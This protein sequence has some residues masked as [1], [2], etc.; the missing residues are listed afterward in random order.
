MPDPSVTY[1]ERFWLVVGVPLWLT[2]AAMLALTLLL[3]GPLLVGLDMLVQRFTHRHSEPPRSTILLRWTPSIVTPAQLLGILFTALLLL[4]I[5]MS[6]IGATFIGFL[7]A[8]PMLVVLSW[9][10]LWLAEVRYRM[11]LDRSLPA[12]VSRLAALLHNGSSFPKALEQVVIDLP[13]GPLRDEWQ[14]LVAALAVPGSVP[15]QVVAALADQTPSARQS[16]LLGHLEVALLQPHT[17]LTERMQAAA[18]ALFAAE[19][20]R[21][22]A[23][24]E[25]AQIRYSGVAIGLAG[26]AMSG[27]LALTQASR[28]A[29]AYQGPIGMAA[30]V[31]LLLAL[32]APV[33]GG[34]LL[35]NVDDVAY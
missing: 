29:Q 16:V 15:S 5:G 22:A 34:M 6:L 8:G 14:F 13:P 24:T 20:R 21:S 9:G 23:A 27:Y 10:L 25:M 17:V 28:F 1:P 18:Q 30:A 11:A 19:Q 7:L 33:I 31:T 32:A 12:A 35:A 4:L 3:R 2:L 26:A